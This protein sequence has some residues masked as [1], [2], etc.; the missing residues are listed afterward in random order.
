M[1][2]IAYCPPNVPLPPPE[3]RQQMWNRNQ[4]GA[5][6]M[7]LKNGK[8]EARK[9][10]MTFAHFEE[11][12]ANL[13]IA[14]PRIL[15]YRIG[16][17]GSN[18]PENTHP[19]PINEHASLVHNGIIPWLADDRNVSDSRRLGEYLDGLDYT[20]HKI[21]NLLQISL[22]SNKVV[23]LDDRVQGVTIINERLGE[24][25]EGIWYSNSGFKISKIDY[26]CDPRH[27]I[28]FQPLPVTTRY[29]EQPTFLEPPEDLEP[30][31]TKLRYDDKADEVE[32]TF[33]DS[34]I[35]A[36]TIDGLLEIYTQLKFCTRL[37]ANIDQT[38]SQWV[39]QSDRKRQLTKRNRI[40]NPH[41]TQE[42]SHVRPKISHPW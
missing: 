33:S 7:T 6:Y 23:I 40:H 5:G 15:H 38:V 39:I 22:G 37:R 42:Q 13:D 28:Q 4:D 25:S 26:S 20:D 34:S 9:G 19:W 11:F 16:T 27:N 29:Y 32:V 30:E 31:V 8:L 3:I 21:R 41:R 24:W 18:T 1:C 17:H 2:I 14:Q 35:V 36:M 12:V 10:F